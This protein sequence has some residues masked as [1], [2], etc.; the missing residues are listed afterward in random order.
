MVMKYTAT[1]N[2]RTYEVEIERYFDHHLFYTTYRP[3]LKEVA[4]LDQ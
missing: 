3:L 1:V 2:G 4:V